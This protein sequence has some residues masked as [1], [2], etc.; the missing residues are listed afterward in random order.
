MSADFFRRF[1]VC[2]FFDQLGGRIQKVSSKIQKKMYEKSSETVIF[3]IK[4]LGFEKQHV[5]HLKRDTFKSHSNFKI[6]L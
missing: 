2:L 6:S 4:N 3:F 5:H 1:L